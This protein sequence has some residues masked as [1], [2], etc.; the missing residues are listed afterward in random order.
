MD[1]WVPI[2]AS[3]VS[4]L[5]GSGFA[6]LLE[7]LRTRNLD[8]AAQYTTFLGELRG[9]IHALRDRVNALN[10]QNQVCHA[11]NATLRAEIHS[12][13]E[14]LG[15]LEAAGGVATVTIDHRGQVLAWSPGAVEVFGYGASKAIGKDISELVI[16]EDYRSLHSSA[17]AKCLAEDR[18][19][20][21]QSLIFRAKDK[22]GHDFLVDISLTGT[23]S[24]G[25][26][27]FYSGTV[28]RRHEKF[29]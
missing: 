20:R 17:L 23:K 7:W 14:R 22:W 13:K 18:P 6:K 28:R 15:D 3:V 1:I 16:P 10:L 5:G 21:S 12:L 24:A 8:M 19:P 25:G 11:E 26:A 27:W 29:S 4:F 2:V 9:E